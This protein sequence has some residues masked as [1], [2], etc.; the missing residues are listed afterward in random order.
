MNR[1]RI[2]QLKMKIRG[3]ADSQT[4]RSYLNVNEY[5]Q[6]YYIRI[7][8][9]GRLERQASSRGQKLFW[10]FTAVTQIQKI[11]KGEKQEVRKHF[12]L[13]LFVDTLLLWK[14][15][16][17]EEE[18]LLLV[19]VSSIEEKVEEEKTKLSTLR[20][21]D[22]SRLYSWAL[23]KHHLSLIRLPTRTAGTHT[24]YYIYS[25]LYRVFCPTVK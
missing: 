2:L 7:E 8:P 23:S 15:G 17:E 10:V 12:S 11:K 18:H 25:R 20:F 1:L 19:V 16:E 4:H 13:I 21:S 6:T 24:A 9:R 5:N 14:K 3:Q 22:A